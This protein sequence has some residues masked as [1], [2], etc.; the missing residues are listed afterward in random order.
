M[1]LK[2]GVFFF[3]LGGHFSS[4]NMYFFTI[5]REL[6]FFFPMVKLG[7]THCFTS[8][9][10]EIPTAMDEHAVSIA[11]NGERFVEPQ[12]N[13]HSE[14]VGCPPGPRMPVTTRIVMFLVG[15]PYKPFLVGNPPPGLWTIFSRGSRPKPSFATGILGG[16]T[17][18]RNH[19]SIK[20]SMGPNPNEPRP[21]VSCELELLD[22][23]RFFSGSVKRGSYGSDF[24]EWKIAP[25][26][27]NQTCKMYGHV[28]GF[29]IVWIGDI[30]T[31]W[32]VP[33]PSNSAK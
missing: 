11:P 33:L 27:G 8:R 6:F 15:D 2:H 5:F 7:K 30:M 20:N 14:W 24:L 31:T 10:Y 13:A 28:E 9:S 18:W 16:G 29:S 4:K 25:F 21:S 23:N 3:F 17:T 1:L 22:T 19:E 26:L 32:V 12:K